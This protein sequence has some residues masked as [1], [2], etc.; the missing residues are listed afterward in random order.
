MADYNNHARSQTW[1]HSKY[2]Y[3]KKD[4]KYGVSNN[5]ELISL[6]ITYYLT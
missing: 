6:L 4:V 2:A 5:S 3:K 1:K